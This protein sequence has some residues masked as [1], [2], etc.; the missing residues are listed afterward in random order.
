MKSRILDPNGKPYSRKAEALFDKQARLR[1]TYDSAQTSTQTKRHWAASDS[2]SA[3]T[4]N[5]Y[6]VR[7]KIRERAR[8]EVDNNS[9]PEGIAEAFAL[10]VIGTGP[11]LQVFTSD[12]DLNDE[13]EDRWNE[14]LPRFVLLESFACFIDAASLTVKPSASQ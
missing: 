6:S 3:D 8:Y 1:A 13:I 5:S 11:R 7:K 4:A 9:Y 10:D 12:D 2:Y 14:W